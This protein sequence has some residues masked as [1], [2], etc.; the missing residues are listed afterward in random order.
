MKSKVESKKAKVTSKRL[1]QVILFTFYFCLFAFPSSAL[2]VGKWSEQKS[3]T[4]AW[5]RAVYFLNE[6]KGWVV[7]GNGTILATEDGGVNWTKLK[8]PTEDNLTDVVFLSE[9]EGWILCESDRYSAV[10]GQ[11]RSYLLHST[12]GGSDWQRVYLDSSDIDL[13]ISRIIFGAEDKGLIFGELG[14]LYSTIDKGIRWVGKAPPSRFLL[15]GG[16]ILNS[17]QSVLVGASSTIVYTE[18][19][20]KVWQKAIL[21]DRQSTNH[22]NTLQEQEKIRFTSVSFINQQKGF[23]VG[24]GGKIFATNDGARNWTAQNSTTSADLYDVRFLNPNEAFITGE[25]GTLLYTSNAGFKWETINL[26]TSHKLERIFFAAPERGWIVG[27]GGK[28]FCYS[29]ENKKPQI[30]L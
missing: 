2:A 16:V 3:G 21:K 28:I 25:K 8:S 22:G 19:G 5:L 15:L 10:N 20:G 17:Q 7:G 4:L 27:F 14:T 13:R 23:A 29:N 6:K 26:G 9:Q 1:M 24:F 18:D 30:S 12:D 11:P